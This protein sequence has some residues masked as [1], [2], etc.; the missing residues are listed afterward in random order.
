MSG[1]DSEVTQRLKAMVGELDLTYQIEASR[2]LT[3]LLK[4]QRAQRRIERKANAAI[5]EVRKIDVITADHLKEGDEQCSFCKKWQSD[6]EL[7]IAGPDGVF[8]CNE[9]V[10]ICVDCIKDYR[11]QQ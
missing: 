5:A 6:V 8:I 10:E 2:A 9:C 7:L 3:N 4:V 11:E 1:N